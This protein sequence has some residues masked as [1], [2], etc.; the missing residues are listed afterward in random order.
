VTPC[1][2]IHLNF[3]NIKRESVSTIWARMRN[4]EA[5]QQSQARCM[6]SN[7]EDFYKE[8]IR[9]IADSGG[10]T[11]PIEQHPRYLEEHPEEA[12]AIVR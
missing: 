3:G 8:Y 9:P 5:F 4:F 6:A 7:D 11:L 12:A 2:F 10:A 1:A